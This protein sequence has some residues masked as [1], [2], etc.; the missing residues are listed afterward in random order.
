MHVIGQVF[1]CNCT[2]LTYTKPD[3]RGVIITL[4][5]GS[6]KRKTTLIFIGL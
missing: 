2:V 5:Q 3:K 4:F 6:N 1:Q